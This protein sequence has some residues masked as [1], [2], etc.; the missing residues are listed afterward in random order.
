MIITGPEG[1]L[2]SGEL[3]KNRRWLR[4]RMNPYFFVA[5]KDEPEAIALLARELGVLRHNRRMI[6]AD[7]DKSLILAIVNQ[8]GTLYETLRQVREREI[9]YTMI[10][11]SDGAMPEMSES[12]EIQ[13]FEFDRKSNRDINEGN[14]VVPARIRQ[15]ILAELRRNYPDFDMNEFDRLLRILWL[16][17]PNYVQVSP[18]RR[19]SLL[20]RLFQQGNKSGGLYLDVEPMDNREEVRVLFAVGNPPQSDFLLQVM[21]VF[22]RLEVGINRAYCL[23]ISNGIHP[24]FL[25]TFYVRPRDGRVIERGSAIF[26]RMEQELSNTQLLDTRSQAY[27]AFVT[28]GMM[29]GEDAS[30]INA[31][32]AFCHSNLAHNQPDRFGLDDVRSAFLSHPEIALQLVQLFRARFE[33]GVADRDTIWQKALSEMERT[34]ADYNSGHRYL[35]EIRRG[36]FRCALI[37]I[38]N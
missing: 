10:A 14:G 18:P 3:A 36:I 34:V 23:T 37:F 7:R 30:L 28:S 16:N 2:R 26:S 38:R 25:G 12:L 4:E 11:H 22:N 17:N 35:D 33:P 13:R 6:M 5:M 27:R 15:K 1:R 32:I 9:S 20:L 29:S 21:E 8:P 24:Y 31:F 19:I